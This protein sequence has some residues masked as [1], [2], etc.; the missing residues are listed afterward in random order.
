MQVG[1]GNWE[2]KLFIIIRGRISTQAGY[3]DQIKTPMNCIG[4]VLFELLNFMWMIKQSFDI[5]THEIRIEDMMISAPYS[6]ECN[7][8]A[9][10]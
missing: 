3:A 5:F 8:G 4:L 7:F 2:L 10:C 6:F 9:S 1:I